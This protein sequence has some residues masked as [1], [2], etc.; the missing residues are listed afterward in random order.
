M[1]YKHSGAIAAR[2]EWLGKLNDRRLEANQRGDI[3][4]L[5]AVA[6]DYE[7]LKHPALTMAREIRIAINVRKQR[8]HATASDP[9]EV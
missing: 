4:A 5:E 3:I 2:I 7:L 8:Q 6:R 9:S 1:N